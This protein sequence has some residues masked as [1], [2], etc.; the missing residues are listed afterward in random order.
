MTATMSPTVRAQIVEQASKTTGTPAELDAIA[1][2]YGL[3]FSELVEILKGSNQGKNPTQV[4][5]SPARPARPATTTTASPVARPVGQPEEI[6]VLINTAKG[7]PAKR[8]QAAGNKLID[9]IDR[10]K[11][12]LREDEEK[13]AER[14]RVAAEKE[15]RRKAAAEAKAAAKAEVQRLEQELREARAKA[16]TATGAT[17]GRGLT[18]EIIERHGITTKDIRTWAAE[19]GV[20]CPGIGVLPSSVAKAY[21][22][23]HQDQ[24]AAS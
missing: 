2:E 14:R 3:L 22:E 13:H 16:R 7:H 19:N 10:L 23:A 15:A 12:L 24:A 5:S 17:G 20:D 8:I 9:D 11:N 21:D 1:D 18:A 4:P 6:R